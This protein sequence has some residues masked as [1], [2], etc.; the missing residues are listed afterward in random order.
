MSL[1]KQL[2]IAV[3]L[4]MLLVF[5]AC[6]I[7]SIE[8]S[9]HTLEQ[10]LQ[11]KNIDN[12]TS[13]ALSL[14]QIDK[15]DPVN[16]ALLLSAQFDNGHYQRIRLV[17]PEGKLIS[18][19]YNADIQ[20]NTPS[21]FNR[22]FSIEVHPGVAQVQNGWSQYGTLSLESDA[23]FAYQALWNGAR[24]M[25]LWSVA[26]ALLAGALGSW[27]LRI[28]TRPLSEMANMAEAIG[29][30]RF[31]TMTEPRVTE[32]KSLA[33]AMNRLSNRI[34]KMLNEQSQLLEQLRFEANYEPISGLMNRKYFT[35]RVSAYLDNEDNFEEGV[36]VVS[37][38]AELA[39]INA[40]LGG[41]GTDQILKR[42]GH[43]LTELCKPENGMFAGRLSGADFAVFSSSPHNRELLCQQVKDTIISAAALNESFPDFSP[44]T[45]ASHIGRSDQLDSLK[46][47]MAVIRQRNDMAQ[48]QLEMDDLAQQ[49]ASPLNTT[50][51]ESEW[52]ARLDNAIMSK[53]LRLASFPVISPS[54]T[55]IHNEGPMRLQL[56]PNGPWLPAAEF[57]GWA[58]KLDL[59]T[60]MDDL[61]VQIAIE[62]LKNGKAAIGLNISSRAVSNPAYLDHLHALLQANPEVADKLWLEVPE[63]GVFR[64]M[65]AFRNFCLTLKPLGCRIGVEHVG[66]QVARL[67]ELNDLGL[68][69]IKIDASV[70]RN[71]DSNTGNQAFLKGL[72]LIVHSLGMIA[73]A[74]GV[75]SNEEMAA[76]PDLGIDGM[77]GPAIQPP[78][79]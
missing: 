51:T 21:W 58:I 45:I 25:L 34:R 28:I 65:E 20:P 22:A 68:S 48:L 64:H 41:S 18:E 52:R 16:V 17:D 23:T 63:D 12:A 11:M 38:I 75:Q 1:I 42:I 47:L 56:E 8:A 67:G 6:V 46:D 78:T 73:I 2:W 9:K 71:I 44:R 31:I 62:D 39:D 29:D 26:I 74:E 36:L 60:E 61:L 70:I 53:R 76:L 30:Q 55:L 5:A 33:Q 66:A 27:L 3:S 10:Q 50:R 7:A 19:H 24:K 57:I 15:E 37:H 54:N 14:S 72:C 59:I 40:K 35:S 13:L 32:F 4:L 77:T 69:Y 49:A 43:A 79:V